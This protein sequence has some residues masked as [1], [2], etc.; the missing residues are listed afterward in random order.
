LVC[1]GSSADHRFRR[2]ASSR[3]GETAPPIGSQIRGR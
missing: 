2:G 3:S 1:A